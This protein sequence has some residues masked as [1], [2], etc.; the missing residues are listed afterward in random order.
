VRKTKRLFFQTKL[1]DYTSQEEAEKHI[2]E[3][4]SNGW[5]TK[6]QD[7]GNIIYTNNQ[8]EFAYSVEFYKER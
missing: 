8:E 5:H 6:C 4:E 7:N 2:K 1:Y 3:M